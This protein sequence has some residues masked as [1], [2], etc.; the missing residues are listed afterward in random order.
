MVKT[1]SFCHTVLVSGPTRRFRRVCDKLQAAIVNPS[2]VNAS[3]VNP[4]LLDTDTDS[5]INPSLSSDDTLT[6]TASPVLGDA[7]PAAVTATSATVSTSSR[8]ELGSCSLL[9]GYS[10]DECESEDGLG[11]NHILDT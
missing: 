1:A 8:E 6:N 5:G 7:T 4:L 10:T 2:S 9:G 3:S 11:N